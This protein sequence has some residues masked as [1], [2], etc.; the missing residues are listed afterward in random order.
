M[1]PIFGAVAFLA[2]FSAEPAEAMKMT[3]IF[4]AAAFFACF[5]AEPAE[6]MFQAC[7]QASC[8]Q[9]G[10]QQEMTVSGL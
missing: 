4:R 10:D 1:T 6:A 3:P 2:C 5:S 8:Q 7:Q 9:A